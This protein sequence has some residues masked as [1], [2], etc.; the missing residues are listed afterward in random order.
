ML[1]HLC[2]SSSFLGR[3]VTGQGD[4]RKPTGPNPSRC[5]DM[6]KNSWFCGFKLLKCELAMELHLPLVQGGP[7]EVGIDDAK[8]L[9]EERNV[10]RC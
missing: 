5:L 4:P 8:C 2:L 9:F 7:G 10:T 1:L 3:L 6:W